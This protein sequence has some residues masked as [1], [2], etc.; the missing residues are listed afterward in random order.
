MSFR[1]YHFITILFLVSIQ[2]LQARSLRHFQ[3]SFHTD[4]PTNFRSDIHPPQISTHDDMK[5]LMAP[6]SISSFGIN[7]HILNLKSV[8]KLGI[9]HLGAKFGHD[10]VLQSI[11]SSRI[12][13]P[14]VGRDQVL[15]SIPNDEIRNPNPKVGHDG[16]LEFHPNNSKI[17]QPDPKKINDRVLET[18]EYEDGYVGGGDA[19][20]VVV[21]P[22]GCFRL[23][24]EDEGRNLTKCLVMEIVVVGE[25]TTGI[26]RNN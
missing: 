2:S 11:P 12:S 10:R 23:E 21:A 9:D 19:V 7:Y 24:G 20:E 14:K 18:T 16:V 13:N 3:G 22:I 1:V 4:Y 5:E 6:T 8:V 15:E 26:W 25:G 17:G